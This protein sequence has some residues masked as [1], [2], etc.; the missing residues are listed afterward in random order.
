MLK[1]IRS[2]VP[3]MRFQCINPALGSSI[4]SYQREC[5]QKQLT[6][7]GKSLTSAGFK[8]ASAVVSAVQN[9]TLTNTTALMVKTPTRQFSKCADSIDE[10]KQMD[11]AI[12]RFVT[13]LNLPDGL[14]FTLIDCRENENH[15]MLDKFNNRNRVNKILQL[16]HAQVD[17]DNSESICNRGF[18]FSIYGNKGVGVYLANHSRY[19]WNWAS[20]RNP[21]LICEVIAKKGRISR[22]RSEIFS[23]IWDSEYV[24]K[25]PELVYP[26]YILKYK[27][28]G[29]ISRQTIDQIGYVKHGE[30]GCVP[31]DS[32]VFGGNYKGTRCDCNLE[33]TIDPRDV[34]EME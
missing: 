6:M 26:R 19:S 3:V 25:D 21:V 7:H 5:Q 28:E 9:K 4:S 11:Q 12:Q 1:G 34:V 27:I 13:L 22:Y 31:C 23:P 33:P 32:K 14:S 20:P 10:N 2:L 15:I 8:S 18:H 16:Y 24:V 17:S 30:F 29:E